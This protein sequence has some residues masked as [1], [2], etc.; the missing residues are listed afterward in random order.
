MHPASRA[1]SWFSTR[2]R[3]SSPRTLKT[4]WLSSL[5]LRWRW[6]RPS[7]LRARLRP[8]YERTVRSNRTTFVAAQG[9]LAVLEASAAAGTVNRI[10]LTSSIAAVMGRP[11]D[12]AGC[13][14][15]T[16]WNLSSNLDSDGLDQVCSMATPFRMNHAHCWHTSYLVTYRRSCSPAL[17]PLLQ[18]DGRGGCLE[19]C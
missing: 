4:R 2:H 6:D 16:D 13:F 5:S 9:T 12:K 17:V 10:V 1:R 7:P 19:V 8:R 18:E 14:D 3:H 15:E 11:G